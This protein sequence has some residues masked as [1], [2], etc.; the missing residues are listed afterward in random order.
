MLMALLEGGEDLLRYFE[1]DAFQVDRLINGDDE[2]RGVAGE[3][4]EQ[5]AIRIVNANCIA[6]QLSMQLGRQIEAGQAFAQLH[7]YLVGKYRGVGARRG[8]P[9]EEIA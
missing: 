5:L 2:E 8:R 1:F 3:D 7:D 4:I 6:D 9:V